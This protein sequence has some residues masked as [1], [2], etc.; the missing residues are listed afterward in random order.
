VPRLPRTLIVSGAVA[1]GVVALPLVPGVDRVD[2]PHRHAAHAG[3]QGPPAE[4]PA[5]ASRA[6]R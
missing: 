1:L 2:V 4:V 6:G 3:V 5:V